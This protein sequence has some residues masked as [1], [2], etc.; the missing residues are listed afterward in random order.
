MFDLHL[1]HILR[2]GI[3]YY[4]SSRDLFD[5][6][7]PTFSETMRT[8]MFAELTRKPVSFDAAYQNRKAGALPLI[9]IENSEEALSNQALA[10]FSGTAVDAFGRRVQYKH[11]FI[12][13]AAGI[14]IFADSLE[15]VRTLQ[16][17]VHASVLLFTSALLKANYENVMYQ[18]SSSVMPETL[19]Q[20]GGT[21]AYSVRA[22]YIALQHLVI[23]TYLDDL[24][25][26][27]A[28]PDTYEI[29]VE[30]L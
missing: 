12:N 30:V 28:T 15:A 19:L 27:G 26:I 1:M 16:I 7:F 24:Q 13:H 11:I 10:D 25:D 29:K 21:P 5:P 4:S 9:T 20:D 22:L 2:N 23:P 14:N 18:G 8:R 17:I 3:K 6:L